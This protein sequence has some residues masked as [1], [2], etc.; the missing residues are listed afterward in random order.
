MSAQNVPAIHVCE[1]RGDNVGVM[2][3]GRTSLPWLTLS[4]DGRI[5]LGN[6]RPS[7]GNIPPIK[8]PE[9]N[10]ITS[11][12]N[13]QITKEDVWRDDSVP[14]K[15]SPGLRTDAA[16]LPYQRRGSLGLA[17]R[18]FGFLAPGVLGKQV[19]IGEGRI[20]RN[21]L[22]KR[23]PFD[24]IALEVVANGFVCLPIL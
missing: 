14:K 16:N 7:I 19:E 2:L 15:S 17:N 11:L 20:I 8:R 5:D 24:I 4:E 12:I 13:G 23:R 3:V 6:H 1:P 22:E 10:P 18:R 21:V 9:V